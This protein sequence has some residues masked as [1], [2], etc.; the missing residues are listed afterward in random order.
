MWQQ[1]K[2]VLGLIITKIDHYKTCHVQHKHIHSTFLA[3]KRVTFFDEKIMKTLTLQ[4]KVV[5]S[6]HVL[7]SSL[8]KSPVKFSNELT[9]NNNFIHVVSIIVCFSCF[10]V[11]L[12]F[13]EWSCVSKNGRKASTEKRSQAKANQDNKRHMICLPNKVS[14]C[15]KKAI[16]ISREVTRM[17]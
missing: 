3:K 11:Y 8:V 1:F 10:S 5:S 14:F 7:K 9:N 4:F 12:S 17:K 6:L 13:A 2:V 15:S 16:G